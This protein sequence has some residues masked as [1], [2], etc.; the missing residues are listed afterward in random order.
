MLVPQL[1]SKPDYLRVKLQRRL[2]R[3]GAMA[4][5]S[6][7]YVLPNRPEMVE[8]FEWL[9]TEIVADGG[10]AIIWVARAMAGVT[11]SGLEALFRDA[12]DSEYAE[13]VEMALVMRSSVLDQ[14]EGS[15]R[16][17]RALAKL[18]RRL[19]EIEK[20]DFF[21]AR[22]RLAAQRA[23]SELERAVVDD[24]TSQSLRATSPSV[25]GKTWVTR[26]RVFVDRIASA[27]L[28]RRFIDPAATFKFVP[29]SGY[30]PR[31]D[32]LRFDMYEAEY[33]HEGDRCTFETLV[34][35]FELDDP[36]LRAVGEVVHD[37]DCKDAKFDR[38]ESAG[39]ESI[40]AGL[41][42]A[43]SDDRRRLELGSAIFDALYAQLG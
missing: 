29:P 11:D 13:I 3:V 42:K 10:D 7:V 16:P 14:G 17:A 32:E 20:V 5:R 4:L 26:E 34:T 23:I 38:P 8:D 27:W 43:Q 24:G 1:P 15:E 31:P 22:G 36:A 25:F 9:R 41:V 28:I 12:R 19:G 30:L 40:L 35:G 6:S 37:I 33:T 2:Q 18:R 21:D 39:V